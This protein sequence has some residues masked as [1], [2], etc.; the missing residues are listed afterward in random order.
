MI[1]S[2]AHNL[3]KVCKLCESSYNVSGTMLA[4]FN[5]QLFHIFGIKLVC[6]VVA[7]SDVVH[8]VEAIHG[9]CKLPTASGNLF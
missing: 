6:F 1:S 7:M 8:N 3:E 5:G 4:G 9:L 2:L